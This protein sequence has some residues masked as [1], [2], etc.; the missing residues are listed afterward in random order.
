MKKMKILYLGIISGTAI[1]GLVL[2]TLFSAN[3]YPLTIT[4]QNISQFYTVIDTPGLNDTYQVGQEIHFWVII[5][6]YGHYLCVEPDVSIYNENNNLNPIFHESGGILFCPAARTQAENYTFYYPSKISPYITSINQTGNYVLNVSYA[7]MSIQKRFSVFDPQYQLHLE[8][9]GISGIGLTVVTPYDYIAHGGRS[10][11]IVN[12][13]VHQINLTRGNVTIVDLHVKH[14]AGSNP[15]PFVSV[16]LEPPYGSI[17]YPP[18][19]A[20]ST[21]PEQRIHAQETGKLIAGSVDLGTLVTFPEKMPIEIEPS[22][23]K[24]IQ[25]QVSVPASMGD[26]FVGQ[27]A[28]LSISVKAVGSD[29]NST[30]ISEGE[31]VNFLIV[32]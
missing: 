27:G 8:K 19:L 18:P 29:G 26:E 2:F 3:T 13:M 22:A 25:M 32:K 11:V 15:F 28:Y 16:T 30:I 6:G 24:V 1:T 9:R 4:P 10:A 17:W 5:R 21:T 7:N 31:G 23:E 20:S 14:L 12:S